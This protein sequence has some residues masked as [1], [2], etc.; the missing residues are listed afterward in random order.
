MWVNL[1]NLHDACN[2]HFP[3]W[4]PDAG[5]PLPPSSVWRASKAIWVPMDLV[6]VRLS[7]M[8]GGGDP[9]EIALFFSW[10]TAQQTPSKDWR[11]QFPVWQ[12]LGL[13]LDKGLFSAWQV[14]RLQLQDSTFLLFSWASTTFCV[15]ISPIQWC[16]G[17]HCS[18][19][20]AW[21]SLWSSSEF[22]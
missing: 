18:C 15:F 4:F 19:L 10:V 21:S 8:G 9:I 13:S 22:K 12:S 20:E 17:N 14:P 1:S 11:L 6:R 16:E 7:S 5:L 2:K 3:H